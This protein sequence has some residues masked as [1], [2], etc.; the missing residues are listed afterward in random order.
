[1]SV[2]AARAGCRG[3]G[4]GGGLQLRADP[5]QVVDGIEEADEAEDVCRAERDGCDPGERYRRAARRRF[6]NLA[7]T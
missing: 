6:L 4:E 3:S 2:I 7:R 5:G 1:M